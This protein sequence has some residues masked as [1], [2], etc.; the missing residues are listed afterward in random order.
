MT[1]WQVGVPAVR[2]WRETDVCYEN[3]EGGSFTLPGPIARQHPPL[4]LPPECTRSCFAEDGALILTHDFWAVLRAVYHLNL[5]LRGLACPEP[6]STLCIPPPLLEQPFPLHNIGL[7]LEASKPTKRFENW[8]TIKGLF[9]AAPDPFRNLRNLE[10]AL[11]PTLHD[12][13]RRQ[14]GRG[15]LPVLESLILKGHRR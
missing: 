12:I 14:R 9:T 4:C 3:W 13:R 6:N 15:Y 11:S 1:Q 8:V 7:P 10:L 5:D 2:K